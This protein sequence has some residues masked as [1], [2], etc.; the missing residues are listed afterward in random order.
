MV[1][2]PYRALYGDDALPLMYWAQEPSRINIVAISPI[3]G[4]ELG[5]L[6]IPRQMRRYDVRHGGF[7]SEWQTL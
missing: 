7:T 6:G 5:C 3:V 4:V 2:S 1:R